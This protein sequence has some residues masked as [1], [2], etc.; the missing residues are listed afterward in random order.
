MDSP[1]IPLI[2]FGGHK[3]A[4]SGFSWRS[5]RTLNATELEELLGAGLKAV[6]P[7]LRYAALGVH[8]PWCWMNLAPFVLSHP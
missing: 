4:T 8:D 6:A 7:R 5:S 2:T 3:S 1:W